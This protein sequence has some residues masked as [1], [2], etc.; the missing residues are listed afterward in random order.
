[1]FFILKVAAVYCLASIRDQACGVKDD[2]LSGKRP[3][4]RCAIPHVAHHDLNSRILQ[5]GKVAGVIQ[6]KTVTGKLKM[7][8]SMKFSF[9]KRVSF[10]H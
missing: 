2:A 1:L 6:G 4:K 10:S 7:I 3:L 9:R 8:L 5:P